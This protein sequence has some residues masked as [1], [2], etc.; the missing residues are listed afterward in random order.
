MERK[1]KEG[2]KERRTKERDKMKRETKTAAYIW[3]DS[4]LSEAHAERSSREW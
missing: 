2:R 4:I 3:C 1:R